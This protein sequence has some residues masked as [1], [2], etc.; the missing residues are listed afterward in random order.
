MSIEDVL[1]KHEKKL[2]SLPNVTGTG[3]GMKE[4]KKAIIVFVTEKIP[5]SQ[6]KTNEIIPKEIEGYVTDVKTE[7][8]IGGHE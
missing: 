3:I 2:L 8:K 6:L 5:E 4:E 1:K 7:L